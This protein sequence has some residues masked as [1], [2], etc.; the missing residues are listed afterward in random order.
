MSGIDLQVNYSTELPTYLALPSH[1]ASLDLMVVA[2]SQFDDKT[3]A[4]EGQPEIDCAGFYGGPCSGDAVR[5][6]PD[7]RALVRADW[8]SGPLHVAAEFTHI[9]DLELHPLAFPNEVDSLDQRTYMDLIAGFDLGGN[10]NLFGGINNVFDKQAP[11][12][13]FRAG[14]DHSTNPQLFDPLGRRFFIGA[15]IAFQ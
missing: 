8:R 13:G 2:T 3:Q 7:F 14:G 6:T 10:I 11:V 5:I 1:G 4:L 12:L 9:G 15:S